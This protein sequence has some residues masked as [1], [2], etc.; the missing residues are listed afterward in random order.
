MAIMSESE[1]GAFRWAL[2]RRPRTVEGWRLDPDSWLH[3]QFVDRME[4]SRDLKII[5]TASDAQTGVGKSTLAFWLAA[6]WHPIYTG[7]EWTAD[8]GATYDVAEFLER[9]RELETGSV[10]LMEEAEQLDARRSMAG[11]NVDF[12]HYWMAMRV[13]Q[14]VSILTLPST[15]ALDKRLRELSDVWINVKRRGLAEVHQSQIDDYKQ[16]LWNEPVEQI[17]WPDVSSHEEMKKIDQL[18]EEKI[19]RGLTDVASDDDDEVDPDEVK[20]EEKQAIAQRLRENDALELSG[21]EIGEIV[22][23]SDAWVYKNTSEANEPTN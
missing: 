4:K 5:I 15:T 7:E 6:S 22:G 2:R 13:R 11:E 21:T 20:R 14:V 3:R 18:K 19:E 9:Y 10:L 17:E 23:R 16:K 1:S 8:T 12:S